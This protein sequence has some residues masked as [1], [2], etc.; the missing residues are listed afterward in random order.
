[1]DAMQRVARPIASFVRALTVAGSVP[2]ALACTVAR[3]DARS[4]RIVAPRTNAVLDVAADRTAPRLVATRRA[5]RDASQPAA[6]IPVARLQRHP[7]RRD[8]VGVE[9]HA[10]SLDASDAVRDRAPPA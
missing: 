3:A 7:V 5:A 1:M 2:V 6:V 8:W 4:G 10:A 9:P